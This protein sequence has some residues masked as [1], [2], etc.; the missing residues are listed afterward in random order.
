MKFIKSIIVVLFSISITANGQ[1]TETPTPPKKP[2]LVLVFTKTKGFRH[3]SIATGVKAL[4]EIGRKNNFIV[5]RTESSEDFNSENLANYNL[6]VFLS[7]TMDVLDASEQKAFEKY[8][9]SGGSFLGVHAASDTEYDW[10][11]YGKL[12]GG[13]FESH[14]N[15]PNVREAKI[16]VLTKDHKSTVHLE[17]NWTRSDEWYNYKNL[18]PK[19]TV[20]MNLDENSY[21]GG[22]NGA[23]HPIAWYHE[24]DGGRAY[25][26][27]G[28]HTNESYVELEFRQHLLGAI[29][30]CLGRD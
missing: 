6:V 2:D 20:V 9:Q 23:N 29:E 4:R 24:Y 17:D 25:Y 21:E 14:P 15:N 13:Y 8:I 18:N 19:V 1:E 10:P 3:E 12:V 26:T 28:G 11:W 16:N 30:W 7:T 22:T 5:L 27:G